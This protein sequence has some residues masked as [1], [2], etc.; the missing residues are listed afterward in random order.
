M[1]SVEGLHLDAFRQ[2]EMAR[3]LGVL[4]CYGSGLEAS[5]LRAFSI[6]GF[7]LCPK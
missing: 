4:G 1:G 6:H 3:I 5:G 7:R 2:L